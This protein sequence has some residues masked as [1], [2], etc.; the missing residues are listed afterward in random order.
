MTSTNVSDQQVID[1][2]FAITTSGP[3]TSDIATEQRLHTRL[4]D[5]AERDG[6]LDVS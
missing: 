4:V 1:D 2:L 5:A 6:V 3:T